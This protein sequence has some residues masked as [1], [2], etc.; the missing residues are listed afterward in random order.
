MNKRA[1]FTL[2]RKEIR[3]FLEVW[4]QTVFAPAVTNLLFLMIFGVAL[5]G[6]A[7]GFGDYEYLTVLVPGLI[8][9]SVMMN[10]YQNPLGSLMIGKYNFSI[11]DLL[12]Y[13]MRGIEIALSFISAALL[14][15]IL[16]GLGTAA[17]GL[18]FTSIP[19]SNIVIV[20]VFTLLL[21]IIFGA[22]GAI[23]GVI[24][25]EFDKSAAVQAFVLTPLIYLGGVFYSISSLPQIA[26]TISRV[27]PIFYFVDGFRYGFLGVSDA[28]IGLSLLITCIAA[29]LMVTI[30][31]I[32]FERGYHL[33]T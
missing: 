14:R 3:R 24:V 5:A 4:R 32:I 16:V 1:V 27:N 20:I 26:Q 29:I 18:F 7:S 13:P 30:A 22:L 23:L 28:P 8:A 21:G 15:G 10:A 25:D 19:I 17:I 6:R 33:K 2:Y 11:F 9:M 12:R 31:A